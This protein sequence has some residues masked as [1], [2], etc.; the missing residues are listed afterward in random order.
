MQCRSV[1]FRYYTLVRYVICKYFLIQ[2]VVFTFFLKLWYS[3][4]Q[5]YVSFRWYNSDSV[6]YIHIEIYSA[7]DCIEPVDQ[8]RKN[9]QLGNIASSY[10]CTRYFSIY[11]DF[12]K[13]LKSFFLLSTVFL[14]PTTFAKLY[15]HFHLF[16]I[17]NFLLRLLWPMYCLEV[18]YLISQYF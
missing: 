4:L 16:S 14:V 8:V 6:T 10:L 9:W 12:W 1:Y 5:Y 17:L 3:W 18:H 7:W 2:W 11:V 13:F 15:F